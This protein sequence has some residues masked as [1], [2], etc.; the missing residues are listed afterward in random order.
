MKKPS[1]ICV[2]HSENVLAFV[3][4]LLLYCCS[5]F[6]HYL[7]LL[8]LMLLSLLLVQLYAAADAVFI[9][10]N[11]TAVRYCGHHMLLLKTADI[12]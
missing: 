10:A 12:C 1:K 3:I 6:V 8:L 5:L 7:L 4:L 9:D 2:D 11:H